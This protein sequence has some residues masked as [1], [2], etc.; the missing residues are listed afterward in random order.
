M[1]GGRGGD[2]G[3]ADDSDIAD[4]TYFVFAE[5]DFELAEDDEFGEPWWAWTWEHRVQLYKA[6]SKLVQ[7]QPPKMFGRD[8]QK[9]GF[10]AELLSKSEDRYVMNSF[11][12]SGFW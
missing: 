8:I 10:L 4:V 7:F 9:P 1:A 11:T 5:D 3:A 12:F 6:N 2:S